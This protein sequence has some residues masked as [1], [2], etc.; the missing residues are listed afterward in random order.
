MLFSFRFCLSSFYILL[1]MS[2][3]DINCLRMH[4]NTLGWCSIRCR[5]TL[6][7]FVSCLEFFCFLRSSVLAVSDPFRKRIS[8]SS[9][10]SHK[11]LHWRMTP[12]HRWYFPQTL[13]L[14]SVSNLLFSRCVWISEV[15]LIQQVQ[16]AR[17]CISSDHSVAVIYALIW[18]R[19]LLM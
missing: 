4:R 11:Y 1:T 10:F 19:Y 2:I 15:W 9:F 12:G 8:L 13:T 18:M 7:Y 6:R 3:Q 5:R 17:A 16:R 14:L